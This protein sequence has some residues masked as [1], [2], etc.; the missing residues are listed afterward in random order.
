[1]ASP[2]SSATTQSPPLAYLEAGPVPS[3]TS[4][5]STVD[6]AEAEDRNSAITKFIARAEISKLTFDLRSRLAYASYKASNRVSHLPIHDL[7][8]KTQAASYA[9]SVPSKRKV[10]TF[11]HNSAPQT[12]RSLAMSTPR[13]GQMAPPPPVTRTSS[14]GQGGSANSGHSLFAALLGAPLPKH[15]RTI[16]NPSAPPAPVASRAPSV[17]KAA[18][19]RTRT[20]SHPD[21]KRSRHHRGRSKERHTHKGKGKE[22]ERGAGDDSASVSTTMDDPD[23]TNAA[24]TLASFLRASVSTS[25]ASPR[26]SFSAASDASIPQYAQ[27][28]A[29]TTT[30]AATA[31]SSATEH[32]LTPPPSQT[33]PPPPADTPKRPAPTD[34]EA[35]EY[36]L[37]LATSPSPVRAR[38][39]ASREALHRASFGELGG[40]GSRAIHF[41][42]SQASAEGAPSENARRGKAL[43]KNGSFSDTI[44]VIAPAETQSQ[45][46][47]GG[48]SQIPSEQ[49]ARPGNALTPASLLPPPPPSP[50]PRSS[51]SLSIFPSDPRQY[52]HA[53]PTPGNFNMHEFVNMSPS[54][55]TPMKALE[56]KPVPPGPRPAKKLFEQESRDSGGHSAP[57]GGALAAGFMPS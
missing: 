46:T 10:T 52:Q 23:L 21:I 47:D 48:S 14:S 31:G 19:P 26:S 7:E 12:P 3:A 16:R 4:E 13:P 24:Q 50:H 9:R 42:G 57:L 35:A 18:A 2:S 45:S 34:K 15:A 25:A 20:H 41:S 6:D 38:P 29:R 37:I 5:G 8:V 40:G 49:D 30:E 33:S 11:T 39:Q 27:S 55:R 44:P 22:K 1:M 36:M 28:S 56:T 53:P 32:P 51:S 54:P 17:R 43:T